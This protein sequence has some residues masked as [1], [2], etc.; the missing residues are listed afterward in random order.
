MKACFSAMHEGVLLPSL[1][2]TMHEGVLLTMHEGV[3][4][5][6]RVSS[7]PSPKAS[8]KACAVCAQSCEGAASWSWASF[9]QSGSGKR[10][11]RVAAHCAI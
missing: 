7:Q 9:T 1:F 11:S 4:L 3:L 10:S 5:T 6:M 8:A 2:L